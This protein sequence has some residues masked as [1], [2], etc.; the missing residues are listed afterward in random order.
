M[1]YEDL[2]KELSFVYSTLRI[3]NGFLNK[4][5][6]QYKLIQY[7][8]KPFYVISYMNI[9]SDIYGV[10][11]ISFNDLIQHMKVLKSFKFYLENIIKD[12][13]IIYRDKI[14]I[15]KKYIEYISININVFSFPIRHKMIQ[16]LDGICD[17]RNKELL[18]NIHQGVNLEIEFVKNSVIKLL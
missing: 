17:I 12:T 13:D 14:N 2:N 7:S 4:T 3:G 11:L 9:N 15:F 18:F 16:Y 6:S 8:N 1:K 5:I 10:A